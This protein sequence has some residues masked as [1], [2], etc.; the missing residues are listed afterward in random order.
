MRARKYIVIDI[1]C[2]E[3]YHD[4]ILRGAYRSI[5]EAKREHPTALTT[6]EQTNKGWRGESVLVIFAIDQRHQVTPHQ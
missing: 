5:A 1:G 6:E 3:C 2:L 4:S